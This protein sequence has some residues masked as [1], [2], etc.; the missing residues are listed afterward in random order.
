MLIPWQTLPTKKQQIT[1]IAKM[2]PWLPQGSCMQ[3][4]IRASITAT[5][6]GC[7]MAVS[8]TQFEYHILVV[9]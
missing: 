3:P 2:P 6:A 8:D 1:A 5:Q 4:G 9:V 7:L